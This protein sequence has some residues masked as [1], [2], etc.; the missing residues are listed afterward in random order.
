MECRWRVLLGLG[1]ID[2]PRRLGEFLKRGQWFFNQEETNMR[3]RGVQAMLCPCID[4]LNKRSLHNGKSFFII[5][6]HVV[7][8]KIACVGINMMRKALMNSKQAA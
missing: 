5:W 1:C 2:A 7:E 4:C 8:Q 6:S 3:N